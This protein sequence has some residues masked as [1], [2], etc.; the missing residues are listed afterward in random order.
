MGWVILSFEPSLVF[1][2]MWQ[3]FSSFT[4]PVIMGLGLGPVQ[5][6]NIQSEGESR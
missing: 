6:T 4:W 1:K 5:R 2:Q 3:A